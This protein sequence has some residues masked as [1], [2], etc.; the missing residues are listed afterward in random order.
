[1]LAS[2]LK[3]TKVGDKKG[4]DVWELIYTVTGFFVGFADDLTP[5]DYLWAIDKVFGRRFELSDLADEKKFLVLKEKLTELPS[6]KIYEG[7]GNIVV[8]WPIT[9]ESLDKVLYMTK[10][11]R[12]MGRG[13]VPDSYVFQRLTY[14]NVGSYMGDPTMS[15]FTADDSFGNRSYIRGLDLMAV[16]GSSEAKKILIEDGDVDFENYQKRFKELTT[17][18][19]SLSRNDWNQN[20]YWSWLYCFKGLLQELPKGY[21]NF[22]RTQAW[23][24]SH[25]NA[26]LASWTQLRHDTILYGKPVYPPPPFTVMER[27]PPG[28]VEPNP[29]FWGRLFSLTRM[30]RMG[31]EDF[32]SKWPYMFGMNMLE[33]F[34]GMEK[35][36]HELINIVTKQLANE[37]LSEEEKEF[38]LDLP[39]SI[40]M[41]VKDDDTLKPIR[42][43]LVA[44]VHT[45]S[46]EQ[47]VVEEGVGYVDIIVVACPL[48]DGKAFLAAGPVFSYYEFKHPMKDRLTDEVWEKMLD[49]HQKPKRPKWYTPLMT[50]KEDS[51]NR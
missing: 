23:N 15:P 39:N 5:K 27:V 9:D 31:L 22:M 44:D 51:K 50:Q 10:G 38:F 28:Y 48:T 26:T 37:P 41:L 4:L 49:S 24:R 11:M 3:N 2:S 43:T 34:Y 1:M 30:T 8:P 12:L 17:D 21:P 33:R 19:D 7:T 32:N 6:P 16:L 46:F 14:P 40:G 20:L 36:L 45:F 18:F 29:V 42:A 47:T 25:L 13:C 35:L